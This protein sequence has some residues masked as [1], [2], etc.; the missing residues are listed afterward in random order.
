MKKQSKILVFYVSNHSDSFVKAISE[1][2]Y[3][4]LEENGFDIFDIELINLYDIKFDPVLKQRTGDIHKPEEDVVN[5]RNKISD[6]FHIVFVFPLWWGGMPALLKGFFDRVFVSG[7]AF[8]Y[9]NSLKGWKPLLLGKTSSVFV[10]MDTPMWYYRYVFKRPVYNQL[11]K[12]ILEFCG[13]KVIDFKFFSVVKKSDLNIRKKWLKEV[14]NLAID[15]VKKR[16]H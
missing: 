14:E 2:Y 5:I 15:F 8:K 6:S 13:V 12:T 3:N 7:F 1:T 4:I 9:D 11:K 16:Y 10:T